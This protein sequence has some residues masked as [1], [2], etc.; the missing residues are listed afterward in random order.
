NVF[1]VQP[2]CRP[3]NRNLMEL[4]IMVDAFRR[5]SARRITAVMPYYG[6]ARQDKKLK[7][8][9]PVTARLIANLI[10]VAGASRAL[11][12]DLHAGQIQGFFDVPVDHL[13]AG[14]LIGETLLKR[15]LAGPGT[16]V[17]SPD[18]GGVARARGLAE[19][20]ESP[21]AIIA[22][23]RPEP[24][25]V[26]ILEIVGDVAGRTCV[27]ID[28]MIDT[29]G[30]IVQGAVKLLERGATAVHACCTHGVLSGDALDRVEKSPLTSLM[31]SDSIPLPEGG[32]ATGKI[33]VIS[34]AKLLANAIARIH[35]DESVSEMFTEFGRYA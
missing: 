9:E 33:R 14:P 22:K 24:N 18:V 15:G 12:L 5:A 21:I 16:V 19:Q 28:D 20:L 2:T 31:V 4:L 32:S 17:V 3:V 11:C 30:S 25:Q 6:Y 1:V 34:V 23:R 35:A 8:R 29:G 26:E 27:M 13:I 10:T 7:P